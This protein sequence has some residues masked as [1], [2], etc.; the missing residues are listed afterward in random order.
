[1]PIIPFIPSLCLSNSISLHMLHWYSKGA[2]YPLKEFIYSF[3]SLPSY[4]SHDS[5][6]NSDCMWEAMSESSN[7]I[8]P[9]YHQ[10]VD[11][12]FL[13]WYHGNECHVFTF[14]TCWRRI[15]QQL[16]RI[17]HAEDALCNLIDWELGSCVSHTLIYYTLYC[18]H[19]FIPTW[20]GDVQ[21]K[22][23]LFRFISSSF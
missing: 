18:H 9:F 1:M 23:Y 12:S 4:V 2:E 3:K 22:P 11:H 17:I 15:M 7:R 6:R 16:C 19:F 13:F 5:S 20:H 21:V 10:L 14:S 8:H